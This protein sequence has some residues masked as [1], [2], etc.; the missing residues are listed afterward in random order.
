MSGFKRRET[1]I[2]R[3]GQWRRRRRPGGKSVCV[4]VVRLGGFW[5]SIVMGYWEA[6]GFIG[7][8]IGLN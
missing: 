6:L 7:T 1:E 3:K 4:C 5:V 8:R 2:E